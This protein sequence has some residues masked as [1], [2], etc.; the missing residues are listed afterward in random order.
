MTSLDLRL[1]YT[2]AEGWLA[3]WVDALREGRVLARR[4]S[5]CGSTSFVPL[6]ACRCG[7]LTGEWV[8]L[9]NSARIERRCAGLDGEFALARFEGA[10]T[11]CVAALRDVPEGATRARLVAATGTLPRIVLVPVTEKT[12]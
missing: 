6:R 9:Q 12:A 1:N 10:D 11:A 4:C 5:A 8:E 3:P 2:L 7:N